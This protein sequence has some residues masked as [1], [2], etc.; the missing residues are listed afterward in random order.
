MAQ[1]ER[2]QFKA[3]LFIILSV[4]LIFGVTLA[5]KGIHTVFTPVEQ[6]KVRFTLQDDIGGLR[7]GDEVRIGGFKVGVVQKIELEGLGAGQTPGLVVSFSVPRAYPLCA[8]AHIA[9]ET[10]VTGT[11]VLNIDDIGSG[12]LLT[13]N[14]ELTGHP[15][16]LTALENTFAGSGTDLHDIIHQVKTDTIPKASTAMD[17]ITGAGNQVNGYLS[18][19]KT[20]F[21][22]TV[23]NLNSITTDAKAK[24]PGILDHIDTFVKQV[25][26]ALDNAQGTLTDLKT[27]LANTKDIT[28]SAR[29]LISGNRGKIDGIINSL[30]SASDS[31]KGAAADLRRS[32]WRLLYHPGPGEMDNLELYDAA[33]QFADGANSMNDAA[34]ALRDAMNNPNVDK[35]KLQKL[36]DQLN[37][38]YSNFNAVEDKLWKG[39]RAQ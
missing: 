27:T 24:L 16:A 9:I 23:A 2:S 30:K 28:A 31:L 4:V 13:D 36:M 10:V 37:A 38:S 34:L 20:D 15:S 19:T 3:G 32:P 35:A 22:T 11:S 14:L 17:S 29:E 6:R 21:R 12:Q 1:R 39:V 8:N 26:T 33:R 25:S 5:L 7:I 18:D